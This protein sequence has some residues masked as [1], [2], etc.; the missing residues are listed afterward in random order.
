MQLQSEV[1][2]LQQQLLNMALMHGDIMTVFPVFQA[3][4]ITMGVLGGVTF[5][6]QQ[7]FN[8][9]GTVGLFVG[10]TMLMICGFVFTCRHGYKHRENGGRAKQAATP[11]PE[12]GAAM[13]DG[14]GIELQNVQTTTAAADGDSTSRQKLVS[15]Q[16]DSQSKLDI[17]T[18]D[19]TDVGAVRPASGTS[20]RVSGPT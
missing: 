9:N 14:G 18:E 6:P 5:Y 12:D 2:A 10:G 1:A 11:A 15:G 7:T 20:D 17:V 13:G 4:W 3:V 19:G 8:F 16:S